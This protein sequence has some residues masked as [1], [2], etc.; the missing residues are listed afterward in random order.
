MAEDSPPLLH[1]GYQKTGTTW[2]QEYFFTVDGP[3]FRR[4]DRRTVNELFVRPNPLDFDAAAT[5]RALEPF[6]AETRAAGALPVLSQERLSGAITLGGY[7]CKE[8]AERLAAVYPGARVLIVIR[9][10]DGMILSNYK[11]YARTGGVMPLKRFLRPSKRVRSQ[12]QFDLAFFEY[13][14]LIRAYREL[15]GPERVL[16]LTY[17]SLREDPAGFIAAVAGF[18]GVPVPP[19]TGLGET[20]N[21]SY[22]G[23][24][25]AVKRWFNHVFVNVPDNPGCLIPVGENRL[26]KKAFARINRLV[27]GFLARWADRRML[28]AIRAAAGDRYRASNAL[29]AKLTGLDLASWG[30]DLPAAE[31]AG[32]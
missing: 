12:A 26:V 7:D 8:I 14:R 18:C 30:Y 28:E 4:A 19:M 2:L 32:S 27:P 1:I 24:I 3:V 20:R 6:M 29:T 11:Q 25:L 15:F 13:D 31:G 5:R 10:Q 22:S 21:T 23:P 16:V 9:K 17:E